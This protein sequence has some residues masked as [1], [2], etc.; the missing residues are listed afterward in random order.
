MTKP[1]HP[2]ITRPHRTLLGLSIP[3]LLSL[4][5]EPITAL[6]DT[7]FISSLGVVPLAALGVGTTALSSL[8]GIFT[9]LG[10]GTQTE[11]AQILGKGESDRAGK[12]LSLALALAAG[13]GILLILSIGPASPWLASILGASG[14]VQ[15]NAVRYMQIRLFGA[16]AVLLTLT[17]FGALRG[18]QD[19]RTPLWIA[20]GVNALNIIL[21]WFL[22]FG[23]GP[24]PVLGVGGSA[25]ASTISQWLGALV[26][27]VLVSRK[28]GLSRDYDLRDAIK[29]LRV[30]G[31]LFIRTLW[32]T[33]FLWFT[34]R[35]ANRI[36]P[37]A[38]AAHQV[39]R[40]VWVFTAL[41]LDAYAATVQSLV[42]YFI[43]QDS[44][45][46]AKGVVR[47]ALSWS[48][49]TGF[50]LGGLMWWGG[51]LVINFLVPAASV[52]V[53][54]P[55]WGVSAISQPINSLAFLTD[56][57]H[58]GTG[59]FQYLSNAMLFSSAIGIS[60]LWLLETGGY[61]SLFW[62]WVLIGI[63]I[64][65]RALFG[66]IRIWPGIGKSVFQSIN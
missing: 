52:G 65:F 63:W 34:T 29:L 43:G 44:I 60:G 18:L 55:A 66:M 46:R 4:T 57:V 15:E 9:F 27:I 58:W 3:V 1:S 8:F 50:V 61:G 39:I 47:V 40:Q 64:S 49:G 45:A 2:F 54:L 17:T 28:L 22:I 48:L 56:G 42:G 32:L 35:A 30:G 26:G 19:M 16:P 5:A 13:F 25:L 11:V 36:G 12:I 6:V 10:V 38:G 51:D 33:L 41:A 53:F 24:F 7:A 20:L 23:R 37:E 14:A 59:D 21:D 31:D 62:V